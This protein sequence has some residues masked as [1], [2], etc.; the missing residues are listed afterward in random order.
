MWKEIFSQV[1]IEQSG[2][3]EA[4]N[5]EGWGWV[6]GAMG[7]GRGTWQVGRGLFGRELVHP[8]REVWGDWRT[9]IV[10]DAECQ[11]W[12]VQPVIAVNLILQEV[13][14]YIYIYVESTLLI[15]E[16]PESVN[17]STSKSD[18]GQLPYCWKLSPL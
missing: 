5:N 10:N 12:E 17:Q 16:N 6:C 13:Y 7:V 1:L 8:E 14:T 4:D 18:M 3:G 9:M 11:R 2:L 15:H